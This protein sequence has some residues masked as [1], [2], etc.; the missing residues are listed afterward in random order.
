MTTSDA[1]MVPFPVGCSGPGGWGSM[2]RSS[3]WQRDRGVEDSAP[4]TQTRGASEGTA[5]RRVLAVV[6]VLLAGCAQC[7]WHRSADP[8]QLPNGPTTTDPPAF[9]S[10]NPDLD[11]RWN[12]REPPF[13]FSSEKGR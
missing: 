6:V 7:P 4:A 5:T 13:S 11:G 2:P 9:M 12:T 8:S 1:R 10:S 3:W